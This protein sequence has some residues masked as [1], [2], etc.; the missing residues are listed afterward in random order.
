VN[1]AKAT[2]APPL[3]SGGCRRHL[4]KQQRTTTTKFKTDKKKNGVKTLPVFFNSSIAIVVS[5]THI[6]SERLEIFFSFHSI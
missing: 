6:V 1:S 4:V 2:L 5:F 3:Y